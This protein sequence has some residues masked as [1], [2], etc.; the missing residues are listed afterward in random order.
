M[1]GRTVIISDTHL[2][3]L[4]G[5][6]LS[7]PALRPLWQGADQF[8]IN[9][10]VAEIHHP[11]QWGDAARQTMQLYDLCETDG[12]HLTMLSGNHDPFISDIRHLQLAD[13]AVFVTHGDVLHPALAPWS[14]AAQRIRAAY[15][16]AMAAMVNDSR[17]ELEQRLEAA[18]HASHAEWQ[19]LKREAGR[20]TLLGLMR[21]PWALVQVLL[22]W[23]RVPYLGERFLVRHAPD[24]RFLII[25]HTHRPG[26]WTIN[27]RV[28]IN[29]GCYGFPGTPRA[30]ILE[31][32]VLQVY[33]IRLHHDVY[34]MDASPLVQ[35]DVQP[36]EQSAS[37]SVEH[38]TG[39]FPIE[40]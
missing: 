12:V 17:D 24:A 14:P 19:G 22:Y 2:G 10:D 16:Q 3:R 21:R 31:D 27:D 30:V 25:G 9:G 34:Q 7:A 20:S 28:I 8:I 37:V 18:Q 39:Q 32:G 40:S 36:A 33:R 4:H 35:F 5:A 1:S 26:I 13:G 11:D 23:M 6:A 29:T 38:A 15:D